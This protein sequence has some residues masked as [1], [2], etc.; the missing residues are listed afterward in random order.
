M[1][2]E[3]RETT[4]ADTDA[5]LEA[6]RAGHG[7]ERRARAMVQRVADDLI[8]RDRGAADERLFK[9]RA[10][11][12]SLLALERLAFPPP[13]LG[14]ANERRTAD[15]AKQAERA[16]TDGA[17]E[18]E[19]QRASLASNRGRRDASAAHL[20]DGTRQ[21]ATDAHLSAE[22]D[23]SDH[24]GGFHQE[25]AAALASAHGQQARRR[26]VLAMVAHDL[27]TPLTVIALS[28]QY[29]QSEE[30]LEVIHAATDDIVRSAA[31]MERLLADLLDIARI[32]SGTLRVVA[33]PHDVGELLREVYGSYGPLFAARRMTFTVGVPP[34]G[35]MAPFDHDRIVQVL[36]NLLG[37][38][39]K[40][41]PAEGTV[42]LSVHRHGS[43]LEFEL[44]DDGPGI[45]PDALPHVFDRFWQ[46]D[47]DTR[48]GLGLGLHICQ[49]IVEGHG[50]RIWVESELGLGTTFHFTLPVARAGGLVGAATTA[51]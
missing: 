38:A 27:R 47:S 16:M 28:A 30:R 17:L 49:Q 3:D 39:M 42:A 44:Y 5:S 18:G 24:A 36:S 25:T 35:I 8:E 32:E 34:E 19:R 41:V 9:F 46:L 4:R 43:E 11:A 33:A 7:G 48:R 45:S 40:F 23:Q 37:N 51:P 50:G 1:V 12:D 6:E 29:I 2:D 15:A 22:R 20:L 21:Q 13:D 14:V 10:G 31:R 26:D